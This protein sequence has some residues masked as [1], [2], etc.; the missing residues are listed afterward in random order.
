MHDIQLV[1][2][3]VDDEVYGLDI[4]KV[5]SIERFQ[6]IV[7]IPNTPAYIEGMINLRGEVYPIINLRKKFNLEKTSMTDDTKI[8]IVSTEGFKVGFIVDVVKEI[9]RVSVDEVVDP[10]KIVAGVDRKYIK[11]IAKVE[12]GMITI[13]DVDYI[14]DEEEKMAIKVISDE[15]EKLAE[16]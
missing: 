8:I 11:N 6:E 5:H 1:V 13:L 7:K 14:L 12:Y 16:E 3:N 9:Q 15:Q 10:P 2:F 4:M